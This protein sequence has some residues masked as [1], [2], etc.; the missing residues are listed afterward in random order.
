MTPEYYDFQ[1][2]IKVLERIAV[3]QEGLLAIAA[4]ARHERMEL[5][6]KLK[7]NFKTGFVQEKVSED[8][9]RAG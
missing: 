2:L 6:K 7:Q 8:Q 9:N 5:A 3:V 1:A 4:E